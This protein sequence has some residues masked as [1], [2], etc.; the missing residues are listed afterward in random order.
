MNEQ[1]AF[2]N[3]AK[4]A[5][6]LATP[7]QIEVSVPALEPAL[8]RNKGSIVH[9]VEQANG[10]QAVEKTGGM[11]QRIVA[12][13]R[14]KKSQYLEGGS[15]GWSHHTDSSTVLVKHQPSAF[16]WFYLWIIQ[17]RP[18]GV[19]CLQASLCSHTCRLAAFTPDPPFI[20]LPRRCAAFDGVLG[21][22]HQAAAE[23]RARWP[24]SNC[25]GLAPGGDRVRLASR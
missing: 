17:V 23:R 25:H 1:L 5:A 16:M 3:A 24:I 14:R 18:L 8:R 6:D 12:R 22:S 2:D 20:P 19:D 4:G 9:P 11:A 15:N 7:Q 10:G 13:P 21:H